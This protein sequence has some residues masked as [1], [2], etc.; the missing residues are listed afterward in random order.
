MRV[1]FQETNPILKFVK[2]RFGRCARC[3]RFAMLGFLASLLCLLVMLAVGVT[4]LPVRL[5]TLVAMTLGVT[6]SLHV[7]L[8][9]WRHSQPMPHKPPVALETK[10][11]ILPPGV[12]EPLRAFKDGYSR[13]D[14][15]RIFFKTAVVA[16]LATLPFARKA[17][18][19]C[20]DCA[21]QFGAGHYD[22]ITHF[23]N[24]VGQ[25]CCPPGSPYLNHCDCKCYESTGD[26]NCSS[27][28]NCLYCG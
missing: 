5:L 16:T 12:I 13:R 2:T 6:T 11:S 21:A 27:Y 26:I 10:P 18:A 22:C 20:G 23:C 17:Q 3:L 14:A 4:G 19:A 28:S 1:F 15:A 25:L 24:N 8:I 9:A 7:F